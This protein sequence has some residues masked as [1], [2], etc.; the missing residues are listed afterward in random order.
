MHHAPF[1]DVTQTEQDVFAAIQT[2]AERD[3]EDEQII[4]DIF[5][6]HDVRIISN[7]SGP[8]QPLPP[9]VDI[10]TDEERSPSHSSPSAVINVDEYNFHEWELTKCGDI[11]DHHW[12][13]DAM[14]FRSV[15]QFG[16][17]FTNKYIQDQLAEAL[18]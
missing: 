12:Y 5:G 1:Y 3:S 6:R 8:E 9:D 15:I 7:P 16:T 13:L 4:Q 18:K 2:K 14:H 17:G 10:A 11:N